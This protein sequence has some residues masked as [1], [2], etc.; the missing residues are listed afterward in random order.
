MKKSL[1][2]LIIT[3]CSWETMMAI[4]PYQ[5]LYDADS[6]MINQSFY[7]FR[8]KQLIIPTSL[9][10]T[11][12]VGLITDNEDWF[13]HRIQQNV[14]NKW[15]TPFKSYSLD[16]Y[17]LAVPALS[18]YGLNFVGIKGK[19]N[20]IDRSVILGFSTVTALGLVTLLKPL[21]SNLRPDGTTCDSWPSGHTTLAF[22]TAEFMRVEFKERSPWYGVAAYG[23]ATSVGVFRIYNNRHWVTDVVAGAGFGILST[24]IAYW[25]FPSVKQLYI[26]S[27][28][29]KGLSKANVSILPSYYGGITAISLSASF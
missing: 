5:N 7:Q 27:F 29:H 23:V 4:L 21:T 28:S 14:V 10:L 12:T 13:D 22:A 24:K 2:I 9:I 16:N 15:N 8:T 6:V 11:S 19:H 20:F 18:V 3:L 1:F 17:L 26:K 25:L